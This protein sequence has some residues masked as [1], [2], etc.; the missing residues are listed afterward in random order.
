MQ[1][2]EMIG[3]IRLMNSFQKIEVRMNGDT[4]CKEAFDYF[5]M[6]HLKYKI[7]Q[8]KKWGVA[9]LELPETFDDYTNGQNKQMLRRKR[10]RALIKG[11]T[12]CRFSPLDR[13]DE[14]MEINRSMITRQSQPMDQDYLDEKRVSEFFLDIPAIYGVFDQKGALQAYVHTSICGEVFFFNRLLGHAAH[15]NNGIMYL[16]IS[17]VIREMIEHK[18]SQSTPLWAMYDTFLGASEGLRFF[19]ERL[20]FKPYNVK[21]IWGK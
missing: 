19:K 14:I 15:L 18:K 7:I 6:P 8:N 21:W 10:K 4:E 20:G 5:T 17:E 16:L 12:F 9:M 11:Y 3:K 1:I 2:S 13:L